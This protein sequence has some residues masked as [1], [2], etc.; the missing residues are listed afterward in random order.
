MGQ[1]LLIR[2]TSHTLR[3][4]LG[5][6][7]H[8][9]FHVRIP[10]SHKHRVIRHDNGQMVR[11]HHNALIGMGDDNVLRSSDY[12]IAYDSVVIPLSTDFS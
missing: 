6:L 2:L 8:Q 5:D 4:F 12:R 3:R 7:F 9:C 10:I 1:L 11:C